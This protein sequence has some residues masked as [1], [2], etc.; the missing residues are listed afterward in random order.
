MDIKNFLNNLIIDKNQGYAFY[1]EENN[2]VL[3]IYNGV[4]NIETRKKINKDNDLYN[5]KKYD[6]F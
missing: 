6:I 4:E 3:E 1:Y 2:R 5:C